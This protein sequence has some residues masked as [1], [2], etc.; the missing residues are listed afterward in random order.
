MEN[1][2]R[3][4]KTLSRGVALS[5]NPENSKEQLTFPYME[6]GEGMHL[7]CYVQHVIEKCVKDK[8]EIQ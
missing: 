6:S 2:I 7:E 3:C 1:C 4:S 5:N 8:L